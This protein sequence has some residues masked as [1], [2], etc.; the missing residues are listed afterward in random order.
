MNA[1]HSTPTI[2]TKPFLAPPFL[3][4]PPH[5]H[6]HTHRHMQTRTCISK[7]TLTWTNMHRHTHTY[8][9]KHTYMHTNTHRHKYTNIHTPS[10]WKHALLALSLDCI[11]I[12]LRLSLENNPRT[13]LK[14]HIKPSLSDGQILLNG[15]VPWAL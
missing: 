12:T 13:C 4:P 3:P 10:P 14:K 5:T 8:T 2:L 7:F 11:H 1:E 9:H 6:T 15:K